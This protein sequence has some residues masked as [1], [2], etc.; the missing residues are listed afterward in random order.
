MV[1]NRK[2]QYAALLCSDGYEDVLKKAYGRSEN[3]PFSDITAMIICT[4]KLSRTSIGSPMV[5]IIPMKV[6]ALAV[7]S[8]KR[9]T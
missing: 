8:T 4:L 2:N 1:S 7:H 3:V 6:H 9:D 5:E